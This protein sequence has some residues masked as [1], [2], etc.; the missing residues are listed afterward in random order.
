MPANAPMLRERMNEILTVSSSVVNNRNPNMED[1]SGIFYR[2][3]KAACCIEAKRILGII[4]REQTIEP[5]IV[6]PRFAHADPRLAREIFK[7]Q[8]QHV[9]IKRIDSK[10]DVIGPAEDMIFTAFQSTAA[11]TGPFRQSVLSFAL[12]NETGDE[13]E[14]REAARLFGDIVEA[15]E[16]KIVMAL[17][18]P[19]DPMDQ[20]AA[21]T[22]YT[23]LH[24]LLIGRLGNTQLDQ[25]AF[26]IR[27]HQA[28]VE[29]NQLVVK[30]RES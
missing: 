16:R 24:K 19:E 23:E 29:L 27:M 15:K 5:G 8:D 14:V 6:L 20:I 4:N 18:K 30:Y 21:L 11:A 2:G 9:T 26:A 13:P 17:Q 1:K 22:S 12:A 10:D 3:L 25:F 7:Q 28:A